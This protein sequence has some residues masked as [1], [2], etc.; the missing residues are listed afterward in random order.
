MTTPVAFD[1]TPLAGTRTG[2]GFS[3]AE[4]M[5]ALGR[6][7][8]PPRLLPFAFGASVRPGV[9]GLPADTRVVRMPTRALL[10][11]WARTGRPRFDRVTRG[12]AVL[13]ATAFVVAPTRLPSLVTV[14]DCAFARSPFTESKWVGTFDPILRRAVARG[15]HVHTSTEAVAAEVEDFLG[16]PLRREGRLTVIA[17]G[18]PRLGDP[19][20]LP[21]GLRARL[22]GEPYVLAMGS[23]VPRKNL[24]ALVRAFGMLERPGVRLVLAGPDGPDRPAIEAVIASLPPADRDRVVLAG[25][26]ADGV[27]RSLLEGADVLAYPSRYEGFGFP[28]LEAMSL[29]VPVVASDV[30]PLREVAGDAALL[31]DP[32]DVAGL[33]AALDRALSGEAERA[34]LIVRGRRRAGAFTWERTARYLAAL[35][36]RLAEP[37]I[38]S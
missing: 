23:L 3:V 10:W 7:D 28:M 15:A 35:Y 22:A 29:G 2:I 16:V 13:H 21:A 5:D 27:R 11:S 26:V 24:T 14:H 36:E 38:S 19:S 18:I 6:L 30:A 32:D 9:D 25:A 20:A 12:A 1:V 8:A 4:T 33:A 34:G 37:T 31:V 17:F